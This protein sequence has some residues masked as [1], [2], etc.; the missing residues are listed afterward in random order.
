MFR[1]PP[2]STLFPYTTLFRS[3]GAPISRRVLVVRARREPHRVALVPYDG[4][5]PPLEA[6][7][8]V[9]ARGGV[10]PHE[11]VFEEPTL[12]LAGVPGRDRAAR[13]WRL[14]HG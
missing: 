7:R 5:R 13:P 2:R 3:L 1:R 4:D 9:P 12:V 11:A 10:Q 6:L 14:R 8:R